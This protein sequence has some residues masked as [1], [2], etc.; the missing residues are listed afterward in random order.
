MYW[1]LILLCLTIFWLTS[2]WVFSLYSVIYSLMAWN[3]IILYYVLDC[4]SQSER[5]C[6]SSFPLLYPQISSHLISAGAHF[7]YCMASYVLF[8]PIPVTPLHNLSILV[9]A[10][11]YFKPMHVYIWTHTHHPCTYLYSLSH[12]WPVTMFLLNSCSGWVG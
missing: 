8:Q 11:T 10:H 9:Q 12:L 6:P 7:E 4:V 1:H 5:E 2:H 3:G